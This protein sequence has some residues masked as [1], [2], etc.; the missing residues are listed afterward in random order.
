MPT[1]TNSGTTSASSHV[2]Y[3]IV[4]FHSE[5]VNGKS[6][7]AMAASLPPVL[8][9]RTASFADAMNSVTLLA[10]QMKKQVKLTLHLLTDS[11]IS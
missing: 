2:G 1:V 7:S 6:P 5:P 9:L 4:A 8:N 11:I 3:S 10:S